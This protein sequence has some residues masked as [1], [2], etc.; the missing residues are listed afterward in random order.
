VSK[1]HGLKQTRCPYC[2]H[3][4]WH[5]P[6]ND[7][8]GMTPLQRRALEIATRMRGHETLVNDWLDRLWSAHVDVL[9][10]QVEAVQMFTAE[11]VAALRVEITEN[12]PP[13]TDESRAQ[14]QE[15]GEG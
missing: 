7:G 11:H 5:N 3:T 15:G 4:Y 1:G 14:R 9:V 13:R 10:S 12:M 2:A 8:P 6:A